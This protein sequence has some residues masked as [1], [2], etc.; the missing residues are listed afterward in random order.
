MLG[1]IL[2]RAK[3]L[4]TNMIL[5]WPSMKSIRALLVISLVVFFVKSQ[6][7]LVRVWRETSRHRYRRHLGSQTERLLFFLGTKNKRL[8]LRA[9]APRSKIRLPYYGTEWYASTTA[10]REHGESRTPHPPTSINRL[11]FAWSIR[12]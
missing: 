11:W 4:L 8:A 9:H 7:E 6:L 1:I 10:V 12:P 2:W 5:L 3:L